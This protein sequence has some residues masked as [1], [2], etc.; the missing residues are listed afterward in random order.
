MQ[1]NWNKGNFSRRCHVES[2]AMWHWSYS[3]ISFRSWCYNFSRLFFKSKDGALVGHFL[4]LNFGIQ[5]QGALGHS[6]CSQKL[7]WWVCS[8]PVLGPV[9]AISQWSCLALVMGNDKEADNSVSGRGYN[10]Q[11]IPCCS[12]VEI[13]TFYLGIYQGKQTLVPG[14]K[15]TFVPKL[16]HV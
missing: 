8:Y 13:Y 10:W 6:V 15:T 12:Y 16:L 1:I 11:A 7:L 9:G 2:R 5:Q 3:R 14:R 4:M